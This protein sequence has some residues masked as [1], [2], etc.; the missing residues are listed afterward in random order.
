MQNGKA[1]FVHKIKRQNI[2]CQYKEMR[3]IIMK[4]RCISINV[5]CNNEGNERRKSTFELCIVYL[6]FSVMSPCLCL[7]KVMKLV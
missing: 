5:D 2:I 7:V 4:W 1:F 6:T 3:N